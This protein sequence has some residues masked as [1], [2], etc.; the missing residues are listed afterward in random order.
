[1]ARRGPGR[2]FAKGNPGRPVG[3]VDRKRLD[4][5]A[6]LQQIAM[7]PEWRQSFRK[8]ALAG[9]PTLDKE[10]LAR[11]MGKVPDVLH[12]ET[13]APLVVDLVRPDTDDDPA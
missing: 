3:A 8:R 13:P 4:L 5:S 11:T 9:D 2:P 7:D 12:L 1:M 10:I 6:W